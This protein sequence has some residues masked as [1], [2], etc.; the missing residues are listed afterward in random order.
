MSNP[1]W[2]VKILK[3]TLLE[4]GHRLSV[5]KMSENSYASAGVILKGDG[6]SMFHISLWPQQISYVADSLNCHS[7][8]VPLPYPNHRSNII[9][10]TVWAA[11]AG[12][13]QSWKQPPTISA[14]MG[15]SLDC[16]LTRMRDYPIT[17]KR[18]GPF[19]RVLSSYN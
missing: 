12:T 1:K 17:P 11:R 15:N 8:S 7:D 3:N 14:L 2:N 10:P 4:T 19:T 5:I 16:A 6:L 18:A 9:I 13:G